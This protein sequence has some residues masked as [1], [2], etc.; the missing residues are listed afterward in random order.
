M[1]IQILFVD[2][3][4][5]RLPRI[6]HNEKYHFRVLS[7]WRDDALGISRLHFIANK[8]IWR[9]RIFIISYQARGYKLMIDFNV[10]SIL[11]YLQI[12]FKFFSIDMYIKESLPI[13]R[14]RNCVYVTKH[15]SFHTS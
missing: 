13:F 3:V 14:L 2:C 15:V 11:I 5:S 7:K 8:N 12:L 4:A 6:G 1:L 9:T 10:G